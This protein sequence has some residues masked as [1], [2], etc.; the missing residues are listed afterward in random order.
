MLAKILLDGERQWDVRAE[1]A[2]R[3]GRMDK[4]AQ[5]AEA[6][7]KAGDTDPN[8]Y[9]VQESILAF[10]RVTEFR[11][12]GVFDSRSVKDWWAKN[13]SKFE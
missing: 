2:R 3:L 12:S 6:L 8:L 4:D 9:V 11:P 1:A 10:S 5:A 13:R 7:A